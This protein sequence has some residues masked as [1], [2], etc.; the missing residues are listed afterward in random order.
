MNEH[1]SKLADFSNY[2][3]I[4]FI[5][6]CILYF[7]RSL[8]IPLSFSLLIS[9]ILYPICNW[10]INKGLS[11]SVSIFVALSA[12]TILLV[13]IFYLLINQI[14]NFKNEWELLNQKLIELQKNIGLYMVNNLGLSE[15]KHHEIFENMVKNFT[16]QLLSFFQN[17]VFAFSS[18]FF[19]LIIIPIFTALILFH[20]KLLVNALYYLFPIEKR[21]IVHEILVETVHAYYNFIKGMIIV[22]FVVG[23]LNSLGLWAIGIPRPFLFGFIASILTFIPYVGII[24]SSLLPISIAWLTYNSIWYPIGVVIVFGFVQL[25]EAN[26]IFPKAVGN[27]LQINT[28]AII[29]MIIIG[30]IIW[31]ASGM[32]LFI[33]FASIAKLIADRTKSLKGLAMLLGNG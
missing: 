7:G 11:K 16:N 29:V 25:L 21:A 19:N 26:V 4:T 28:L 27:R 14:I 18:S 10:L 3:L 17:S 6:L 13:L 33:P 9:F 5:I 24:I 12:I 22:Y 30:G 2:L 20:N 1:Q 8:F 31:G 15:I 23:V 32:I